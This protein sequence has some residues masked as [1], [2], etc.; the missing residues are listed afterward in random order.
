ML[1]LF[2]NRQRI[3]ALRTELDLSGDEGDGFGLL[4]RGLFV[5][6]ERGAAADCAYREADCATAALGASRQT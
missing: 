5:G 2:F 4:E 1:R 3:N 6:P